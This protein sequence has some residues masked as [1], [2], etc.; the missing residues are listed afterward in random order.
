MTS[1]CLEIHELNV[2]QGDSVLIVNR[3]LDAVKDAIT[4]AKGAAAVPAQPIDYL[5]YA[6]TNQ[7]GILG[8]VNQA[9]LIDGGDD[10]YGGDVVKILM[11]LGVID[12]DAQRQDN[13]MLLL[14]HYHDDHMAGLRHMFK[15]RQDVPPP[16]QQGKKKKKQAKPKTEIV[17]WTRPAV[18]YQSLSNK[19][20]N[21][22]TAGFQ[23]FTDDV[24]KAASAA[25]KRTRQVL[26]YPGGLDKNDDTVVISLGA[27]AGAIP[28]EAHVL[29]SGQ[30]VY[31]K[32]K[33]KVIEIASVGKNVDQ[34]DRS[35]ALM[36]QYGSF[37]YFVGGDIAGNGLVAGG[38]FGDNSMDSASK[39][40]YS[41]HADVETT[42]GP[43]LEAYFPA[44]PTKNYATGKPKFTCPGYCTVMKANHHGSSSS[45]DVHLLGT[46]RPLLLLISAGVKT[47]FHNHPTQQVL[48]RADAGETLQWGLR[49][50][51]KKK[52]D[53]VKVDNT[54]EQ[55]Y[56]TEVAAKVR[57]TKF[58]VDVY[59]ARI[60]G[61]IVVRP[62]DETVVAVQNATQP[63]TQLTVQVYG[64]GE[65]SILKDKTSALR[66]T[67]AKNA[68]GS[69]YP[70]GP[71]EHSDTH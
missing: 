39:K 64:V 49:A 54:I 58:T 70:I 66:P 50:A 19:K 29:A 65:L 7:V 44:T 59:N 31:N 57:S 15:R 40:S 23:L 32:A 16:K 2:G 1:A 51:G 56:V 42:L 36:L 11:D 26:I 63:G 62:V 30:A 68:A 35:I 21:P 4:K 55:I 8:T 24:Q 53:T 71:F 13:L 38:N 67:V 45:V 10:E 46:L 22:T 37:R 14:S 12:P 9:L 25:K 43:A 27:G 41:V 17:D 47:R 3:N 48:N 60:M 69:T 5:P 61:D 33:N 52:A 28:I 18:V 34:N 20:T 6:V